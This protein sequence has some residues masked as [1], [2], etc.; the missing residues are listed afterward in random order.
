MVQ[1]LSKLIESGLRDNQSLSEIK[2]DLMGKGYLE[3]DI[4]KDLE[5]I[6][7]S[8]GAGRK[9]ET[10][11]SKLKKKTLLDK[12]SYGFSAT[13]FIN[14]LFSMTGASIFFIGIINA[15]KSVF[16]TF[17]STILTDYSKN[18]LISDKFI[19]ISGV[20]FGFSFLFLAMGISLRSKWIFA[21]ALLLG[22]LGVVSYGDSFK[23]LMMRKI[24]KTKYVT[25]VSKWAFLGIVITATSLLL[26]GYIL[27][28]IPL[29]GKM[30][31]VQVTESLKFPY[32]ISGYLVIFMVT[33]ISA[34]I[35]AY[36]LAK[37]NLGVLGDKVL[38][39]HYI[40][41]FF[42]Q[43]KGKM[44]RFFRNRNLFVLTLTTLV[45][46]VFQSTLNSFIGIHIYYTYEKIWF[47][48]FLNVAAIYALALLVS[49]AGPVL[50]SKLNKYLGLTPM[51]VFGSLIMALLP[52][53]I[54]FNPT[55]YYPAILVATSL[56]V[57][58]VAMIG[59][60]QSLFASRLLNKSDREIYYASSGLIILPVFVIVVGFLVSFAQN[61]GLIAL[62][63]YIGIG[64][65][66]LL[67]P[68]YFVLVLWSS[69]INAT[70]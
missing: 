9:I 2:S 19:R 50:T 37:M 38:I 21:I 8:L 40:S 44:H 54:V 35:S 23:S 5:K 47:G 48:G 57:L 25:L 43:I 60:V 61:N 26:S 13:Q 12:M 3:A 42:V 29:T 30:F 63:K 64:V 10:F 1:Q 58:G 69:K 67:L 66:A 18:A 55:S 39:R 46:A 68:L 7:E 59:S 11:A 33:A 17:F 36:I 4:D 15:F 51:F 16:S 52:L 27:D 62:F 24:G 22:S 32:R 45:I 28:F 65:L 34:I 56:S 31:F 14:I 41:F 70:A 49:F 6:S 20:I 53:T